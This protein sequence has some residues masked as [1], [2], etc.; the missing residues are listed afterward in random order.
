[1][2]LH[3]PSAALL[4]HVKPNFEFTC[5]KR[6]AQVE[7]QPLVVM[8]LYDVY[9]RNPQL[10]YAHLVQGLARTQMRDGMCVVIMPPKFVLWCRHFAGI[11]DYT[12]ISVESASYEYPDQEVHVMCFHDRVPTTRDTWYRACRDLYMDLLITCNWKDSPLQ[13]APSCALKQLVRKGVVHKVPTLSDRIEDLN[14]K[15]LFDNDL[16]FGQIVNHPLIFSQTYYNIV[17]SMD[18]RQLSRL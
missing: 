18:G 16:M 5:V 3:E 6:G 14:Y 2:L 11:F 1:V 7:P 10:A 4:K 8:D 17:L 9:R 15:R 13:L 12:E